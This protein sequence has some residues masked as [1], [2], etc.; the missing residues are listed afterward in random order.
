MRP[1]C[2][3]LGR[4]GDSGEGIPLQSGDRQRPLLSLPPTPHVPQASAG[5]RHR[6]ASPP[7]RVGRQECCSSQLAGQGRLFILGRWEHLRQSGGFGCWQLLDVRSQGSQLNQGRLMAQA[8]SRQWGCQGGAAP[9]CPPFSAMCAS[10]L[11]CWVCSDGATDAGAEPRALV[12][13]VG[14]REDFL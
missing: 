14:I 10:E 1:R 4:N 7:S 5:G 8:L 13:R 2:L 3:A 6:A 9:P 11:T 12:N